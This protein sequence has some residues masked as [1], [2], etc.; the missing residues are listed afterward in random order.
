MITRQHDHCGINRNQMHLLIAGRM[1]FL[2]NQERLC[3]GSSCENSDMKV[4]GLCVHR[5]A[6]SLAPIPCCNT[7]CLSSQV[8]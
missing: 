8:V 3:L 5:P 2:V 1:T 4:Q 6:G 7:D